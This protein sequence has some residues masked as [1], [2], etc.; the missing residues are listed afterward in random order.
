M[1][2]T[3]EAF[4]NVLGEAM[5]CQVPCIS[6]NVGDAKLILGNNGVLVDNINPQ[7]LADAILSFYLISQANKD[8]IG[9]CSR[10]HITHNFDIETINK[11]YNSLYS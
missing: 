2:S 5:L 11:K 10:N 3:T 4:P 8:V 7:V 6:N 1:S 9:E